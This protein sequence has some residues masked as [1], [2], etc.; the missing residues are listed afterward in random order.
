MASQQSNSS[1]TSG[2]AA[3]GQANTSG[4]NGVNCQNQEGTTNRAGQ[5]SQETPVLVSALR[6][7]NRSE[8][9]ELEPFTQYN[10]TE[11]RRNGTH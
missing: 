2:T 7:G 9:A 6:I 11:E 4:A 3:A 1:N 5:A 10:N 8:A